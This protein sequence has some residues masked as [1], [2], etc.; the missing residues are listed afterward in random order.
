MGA[1]SSSSCSGSSV[2]PPL[3]NTVPSVFSEKAFSPIQDG[4][5][6]GP[7][8][9]EGRPRAPTAARMAK[10]PL[11]LMTLP[12]TLGC[13]PRS[14]KI[15]SPLLFSTTHLLAL[16]PQ[17][18]E[19]CRPLPGELRIVHLKS[20]GCVAEPATATVPSTVQYSSEGSPVGTYTHFPHIASILQ[21][22]VTL[23][24]RTRSALTH[25]R[26]LSQPGAS[27]TT[28]PG[29]PHPKMEQAHATRTD[30]L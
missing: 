22:A 16:P 24:T 17:P 23:T 20:V 7:G 15:P 8:V 13:A 3:S 1:S 26:G 6:V 18:S 5:V 14:M 4:I 30:S 28:V 19:K 11:R 27:T 21:R 2:K 25:T 12:L 9:L 10:P 29:G